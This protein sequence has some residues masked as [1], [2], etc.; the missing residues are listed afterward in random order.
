MNVFLDLLL[1][2][3]APLAAGVY[4]SLKRSEEGYPLGGL[5]VAAF[6]T[7]IVVMAD[8]SSSYQLPWWLAA[9][10][11]FWVLPLKGLTGPWSLTVCLVLWGV[12]AVGLWVLGE[13]NDNEPLRYAFWGGLG[14]GLLGEALN[15]IAWLLRLV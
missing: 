11:P 12:A 7:A 10:Q 1:P 13:S 4:L 5:A 15:V 2:I 8:W 9:G 3:G 6:L 14:L